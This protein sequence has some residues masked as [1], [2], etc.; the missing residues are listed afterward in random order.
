MLYTY[1]RKTL[2]T[3]VDTDLIKIDINVLTNPKCQ[4]QPRMSQSKGS[5]LSALNT[6]QNEVTV[7]HLPSA[8]ADVSLYQSCKKL[9]GN[10]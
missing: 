7:G 1:Y 3:V 8:L 4:R 6:E 5:D 2:I 10:I 9:S